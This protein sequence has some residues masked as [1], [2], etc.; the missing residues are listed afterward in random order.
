[1][2]LQPIVMVYP[3]A[4]GVYAP[5]QVRES[6]EISEE[7]FLERYSDFK[8]R[9]KVSFAADGVSNPQDVTAYGRGFDC[10]WIICA[11]G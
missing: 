3:N 9:I 2:I 10:W 4:A 1:M 11:G 8:R 5:S 6:K 7:E